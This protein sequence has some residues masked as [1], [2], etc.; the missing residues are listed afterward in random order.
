MNKAEVRFHDYSSTYVPFPW[1]KW[2]AS[3]RYNSEIDIYKVIHKTSQTFHSYFYPVKY[4]IRDSVRPVTQTKQCN[5]PKHISEETRY[6]VNSQEHCVAKLILHI[7]STQ[8]AEGI[9]GN[10]ENKPLS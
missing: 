10:R 4:S 8:V 2:N 1:R 6:A 3:Y 5:P 7:E 9:L